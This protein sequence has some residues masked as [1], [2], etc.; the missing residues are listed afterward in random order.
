MSIKKRTAERYEVV[1]KLGE[2]GFGLT[3]VVMDKGDFRHYVLKEI[4]C[5]TAEEAKDATKE[6]LQR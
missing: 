5:E 2:G 1:D 3:F 6:V 4:C